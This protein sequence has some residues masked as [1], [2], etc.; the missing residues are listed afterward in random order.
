MQNIK[1]CVSFKKARV[2]QFAF[3]IAAEVKIDQ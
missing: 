1:L 2:I 3:F